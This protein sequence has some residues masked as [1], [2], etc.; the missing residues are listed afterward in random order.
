MKSK[1]QKREECE[2]RQIA[3]DERT[4]LEQIKLLSA[5]TGVARRELRKLYGKVSDS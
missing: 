4:D 5:R 2:A 1:Q 3:R